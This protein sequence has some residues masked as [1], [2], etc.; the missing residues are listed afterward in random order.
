[1]ALVFHRRLAKPVWAIAFLTFALTASPSGTLFLMP[2]T[3]LFVTALV[4]IALIAF[5]MPDATPW[6][7]TSRSLV[8]V[9]PPRPREKTAAAISMAAGNCVHTFDERNRRADDAL[10]F[11]RMDDD[12]GWQLVRPPA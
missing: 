8:R 12:G 1:M 5:T 3:T 9:P 10:D 2:P 6:L 11:A 7:H 4:G